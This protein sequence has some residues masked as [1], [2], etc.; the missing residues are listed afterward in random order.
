V[1]APGVGRSG[2]HLAARSEARRTIDES[3]ARPARPVRSELDVYVLDSA[4]AK[5]VAVGGF[6]GFAPFHSLSQRQ[7]HLSR[8][9]HLRRCLEVAAPVAETPPPIGPVPPEA[10]D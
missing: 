1:L 6:Q 10:P 2:R 9:P 4:G 3:R 8:H 7:D 5:V